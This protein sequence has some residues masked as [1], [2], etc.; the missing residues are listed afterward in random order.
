M[1]HLDMTFNYHLLKDNKHT[2]KHIVQKVQCSI[3]L[4]MSNIHRTILNVNKMNFNNNNIMKLHQYPNIHPF[5]RNEKHVW[6]NLIY[7]YTDIYISFFL[8]N[9]C[10]MR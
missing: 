1:I 10:C 4:F 3:H 5:Y 9:L 2:H 8:I 6:Q 7:I